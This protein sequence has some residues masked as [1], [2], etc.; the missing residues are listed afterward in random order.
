MCCQ[1]NS[2]NV[3]LSYHFVLSHN[4]SRSE[5]FSQDV[6]AVCKEP[7]GGCRCHWICLYAAS[8]SGES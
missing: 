2:A 4:V 6:G 8:S 3:M 1:L 7:D 5:I